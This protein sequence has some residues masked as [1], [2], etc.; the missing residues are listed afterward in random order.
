MTLITK[1][2]NDGFEHDHET[3]GFNE[4]ARALGASLEHQKSQAWL[5]GNINFRGAEVDALFIKEPNTFVLLELKDYEGILTSSGPNNPWL[6]NE[7]VTVRGGTFINPFIQVKTNRRI[8]NSCLRDTPLKDKI[9]GSVL[10]TRPVQGI[11]PN[12]FFPSWFSIHDVNDSQDLISNISPG[13]DINNDFVSKIQDEL[14]GRAE[15]VVFPDHQKRVQIFHETGFRS[16][17]IALKQQPVHSEEGMAARKIDDMINRIINERIN[18]LAG[19]ERTQVDEIES[20]Q[21]V[22]FHEGFSILTLSLRYHEIILDVGR[23][24]VLDLWVRKNRNIEFVFDESGKLVSTKANNTIPS[25]GIYTDDESPYLERLQ[26]FSIKNFVED[27]FLGRFLMGINPGNKDDA[28]NGVILLKEVDDK[29]RPLLTD[30]FALLIEG[31]LEQAQVKLDLWEGT[32]TTV[33]DLSVME[34]D[35][36]V[37]DQNSDQ[38]ID[39]QSL[40]SAEWN[41]FLDPAKFQEWMLLL[42]PAQKKYVSDDYPK[43]TRLHG[44]SGSGKTSVLIHR[45]VRLA[46]ECTSDEKVLI[47]TL[48]DALSNLINELVDKLTDGNKPENLEVEPYYFFLGRFLDQFIDSD[49][50]EFCKIFDNRI[51]DFL[52]NHENLQKTVTEMLPSRLARKFSFEKSFENKQNWSEFC[53]D[54]KN[55][56]KLDVEIFSICPDYKKYLWEELTL[57][58]SVSRVI[59]SYQEYS[60]YLRLG[61]EV[62]F[63]EKH[64]TLALEKLSRWESKMVRKGFVDEMT[65]TQAVNFLVER[66]VE[67]PSQFKYRSILVDEYQDLSTYD[68]K[69]LKKLVLHSPNGL[70]LTGD[71]A[72]KINAKQLNIKAALSDEGYLDRRLIHNYRNSKQILDMGYQMLERVLQV[73]EKEV[74]KVFGPEGPDGTKI[75]K[76]ELAERESPKPFLIKTDSPIEAAWKYAIEWRD[77]GNAPFTTCIITVNSEKIS[78]EQIRREAPEGEESQLL[79][80]FYTNLPNSFVVAELEQIKGFEFLQVIILGA[81]SDFFPMI[82]KDERETSLQDYGRDLLRLYVGVTRARDELRFLYEKRP[83]PFLDLVRD[84]TTELEDFIGSKEDEG[85]L[86][87]DTPSLEEIDEY[88]VENDCYAKEFS[89]EQEENLPEEGP[90]VQKEKEEPAIPSDGKIVEEDEKASE[91]QKWISGEV[92]VNTSA[93]TTS[94][95]DSAA[96]EFEEKEIT[97]NELQEIHPSSRHVGGTNILTLHRPVTV[98][99]MTEAMGRDPRT[100]IG[101]SDHLRNVCGFEHGNPRR[102]EIADPYV[103]E[104]LKRWKCTVRFT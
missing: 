91:E 73:D 22:E 39:L 84:K 14:I 95:N 38:L 27:K 65:L 44:V 71:I 88:P 103:L 37:P 5:W 34:V 30:L 80:G 92:A 82:W 36:L 90:D 68:I 41:H 97:G 43:T 28:V 50:S 47:L 24:H 96:A 48:S 45:A 99:K 2:Y 15:T 46:E 64:R 75:L 93:D 35:P 81:E 79:S 83:S 21:L 104:T 74:D 9:N 52:E 6:L 40:S 25:V 101:I 56:S 54:P 18:P 26:D 3:D 58:R 32:S 19:L 17:L 87:S 78:V 10:F 42:S 20:L 76:P 8:L 51:D 31:K 70:F 7:S 23:N 49:L 66:G 62:S 55:I 59:D 60:S 1:V 53:D 67:T 86:V 63:F 102:K 61:R 85:S 72:Q 57:I 69:F 16:S 13:L 77:G 33:R 100:D 12:R 98:W 94:A 4:L 29:T 89:P 11:A